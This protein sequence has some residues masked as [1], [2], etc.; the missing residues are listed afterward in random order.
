MMATSYFSTEP[1]LSQGGGS[2]SDLL[3]LMSRAQKKVETVKSN[4]E[5]LEALSERCAYITA[6][7]IVK[8]RQN[9]ASEMDVTPLAEC[10]EGVGNFVGRCSRRGRLSRVLKASDDREEIAGLNARVDQL[11]GDLA[12]AGIAT[13]VRFSWRTE[14]FAPLDMPCFPCMPH[15]RLVQSAR[16][17]PTSSPEQSC[18]LVLHA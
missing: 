18:A 6:C 4:R 12:L 3:H 11:T 1:R 9:S 10:V 15:S 7:A 17:E 16:R 2:A 14:L 8:C 5:G 13:L